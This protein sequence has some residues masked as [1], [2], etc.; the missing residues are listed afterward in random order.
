MSHERGN[1]EL[2][3]QAP[4]GCEDTFDVY[5]SGV[6]TP[7][8]IEVGALESFFRVVEETTSGKREHGEFNL[9]RDAMDVIRGG[10][11]GSMAPGL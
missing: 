7:F 11:R 9:I 4:E 5:E 3:I 10:D 1:G 2:R 6:R 8:S